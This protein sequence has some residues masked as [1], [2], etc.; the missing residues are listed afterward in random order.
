MVR[1]ITLLVFIACLTSVV[2]LHASQQ[3][4]RD[5]SQLLARGAGDGIRRF[6]VDNNALRNQLNQAPH[7]TLGD[8]SRLIQLPLPDG[9]LASFTIVESPVMKPALAARYPDIKTY[10]IYAVDDPTVSGRVDITPQGFHAMLFTAKGRLFIDPDR[11]DPRAGRY[12]S[13]YRRGQPSQEFS[14]GTLQ[15]D[16]EAKPDPVVAARS[17]LRISGMLLE[18][19]LAVA[20]TAEYVVELGGTVALAQAG[21]VTAINR[22]NEIYERDLGIRLTLVADNDQL[23]ENGGNVSFS[24]GNLLAMLDENQAW[25]DQQ[26]TSSDYDIGHVFGTGNGGVAFLGSAC[27]DA[28]KA[29]GVTSRFDPVGEP[30]YIDFVA[31][32]IGHQFN[33]EH[34][35]NGTTNSC[36]SGRNAATAF[37]PGSGSSIMAYAGICGQENLQLNSD[38]TFHA[39][40]IAKIDSF[41]RGAGNCA[42]PV[43]TTPANN[44]DPTIAAIPDQVIPANT[45]FVLDGTAA[46][47]DLNTLSYQWDQMNVGCPTS[48]FSFGTD[49]GSNALFRSYIPRNESWRNFPALGTQVQ[50]RFDKAE[51]LPCQNRDLDFRLT[52]RDGNSGQDIED[53]RV[54]VDKSAGPFEITNLDSAPLPSIF[55]GTPFAVDWNVANTDLSPV[56]C[57]NVEFDLISFSS[58]YNRYSIHPL[59]AA[60]N[61]NDGSEFV[62]LN[63]AIAIPAT[64][65]HQRSRVRVKCSDNIFYDISDTDL[66]VAATMFPSVN[67]SDT[68]FAA[69]SFANMFITDPVAPVCGAVVDCSAPRVGNSGSKSSGSGAID[70]LW[71]LMMSGMIALVKLRR[72]YG[73]Q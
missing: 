28:R 43:A 4:W 49:N 9:S 12:L 35:F 38:A 65:A 64:A 40:S 2:E 36:G 24:N 60:S 19:D 23:I 20:A 30:F 6:E 55:A 15:S 68:D 69:Y 46:D 53:V 13:R 66:S 1:R 39:G 7:E 59:D 22:V 32:E 44:N 10:K 51:V 5:V 14:C 71:L 29:R 54:S 41:T 31:H 16:V 33:A 17:A 61:L 70:T 11:T 26:L 37:E 72:R 56:N 8:R 18:Y 62:T 57:L 25:L 48:S 27:D 50:G 47:A 3:I 21:I 34:S 52:A 67:L 58:G 42:V 63:P 45:P 73:L